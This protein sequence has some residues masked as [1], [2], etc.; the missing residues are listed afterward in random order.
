MDVRNVYTGFGQHSR[1]QDPPSAH[2][3]VMQTRALVRC[4]PRL[5]FLQESSALG[6]PSQKP[7]ELPVPLALNIVQQRDIQVVVCGG[8][9]I[10]VAVR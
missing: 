3:W 7:F 6:Q 10:V 9:V 8:L 2:R 4:R 1:D 5:A